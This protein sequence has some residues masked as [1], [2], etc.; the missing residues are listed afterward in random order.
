VERAE[1]EAEPAVAAGE[2]RRLQLLVIDDE[3]Q[4]ADVTRRLLQMGG[5]DVRV[6]TQPEEVFRIW[7]E[8]AASI[9][10]VICDVAMAHMRGPELIATLAQ[11]EVVPHVLFITGYSEEAASSALGHPVL[12]K[13]FTAAALERA[14]AG[15]VAPSGSRET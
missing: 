12:A 2:T 14:V 7:S 3:A 6:A 10:L 15:A 9:D 11:G 8:H 5:H 13:P 1:L 4:V